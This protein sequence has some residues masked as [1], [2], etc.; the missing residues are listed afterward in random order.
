MSSPNLT[1]LPPEVQAYFHDL[2]SRLAERNDL[3]SRYQKNIIELKLRIDQL[4]E[5]FRL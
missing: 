1:H 3:V 2:E 5:Q 4:E